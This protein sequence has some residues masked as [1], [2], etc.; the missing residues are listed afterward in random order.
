[1]ILLTSAR[2]GNPSRLLNTHERAFLRDRPLHKCRTLPRPL[3]RFKPVTRDSALAGT[4][5]CVAS[6][7]VSLP[8]FRI[9]L[10]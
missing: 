10:G 7:L 5:V 4:L 8:R 2:Q 1:M 9:L 3:C 6:L